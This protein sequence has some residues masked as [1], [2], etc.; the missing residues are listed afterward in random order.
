VYRGPLRPDS[1]SLAQ[2]IVCRIRTFACCRP[3]NAQDPKPGLAT[4]ATFAQYVTFIENNNNVPWRN[5]NVVAGPPSAGAP[6][7]FYAQRF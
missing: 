2:R 7:G 5:F 6:Q 3:G 1:R 4:L